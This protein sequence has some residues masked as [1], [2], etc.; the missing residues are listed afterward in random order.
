M[1]CSQYITLYIHF[2]LCIW[3]YPVQLLNYYFSIFI[4]FKINKKEII[5]I[6]FHK[7]KKKKKKNVNTDIAKNVLLL[8]TG[9]SKQL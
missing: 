6:C 7:K 1:F 4:F 2:Y 3:L 5:I 9:D 8:S